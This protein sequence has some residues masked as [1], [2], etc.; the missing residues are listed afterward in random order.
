VPVRY[1]EEREIYRDCRFCGG[2]GCLACPMEADK[3]YRKAFPNGPE[4]IATFKRDDPEDMKR[5]KKVFG[6]DALNKAFGPGGDGV[7]EI[8]KNL[9]K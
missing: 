2:T 8:M 9:N 1:D 5:F 3:A 7:A 4:P 6:A